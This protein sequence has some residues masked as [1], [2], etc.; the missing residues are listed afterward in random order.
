MGFVNSFPHMVVASTT[1]TTTKASASSGSYF[2]LVIIALFVLLYF[3]MI[4][5]NQRRRMQAMRQARTYDLG[6]EVVA[7]GMVGHVVKIG[8]GEVD[9][10]ISD[11]VVVQFLPQA[12]QLKSAYLAGP[13]GRGLGGGMGG[14]RPGG[15]GALGAGSSSSAQGTRPVA[16]QY[17]GG[18]ADGNGGGGGDGGQAASSSSIGS[19]ARSV[20]RRPASS[21]AWP[22]VSATGLPVGGAGTAAGGGGGGAAGNNSG[23]GADVDLTGGPGTSGGAGT[24]DGGVAPAGGET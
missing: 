8:D 24:G 3:F 15:F 13:G 23:S 5:P 9:V 2:L 12:V 4:R 7:A 10:E 1:S 20:R 22:D 16:G 11:G 19:R 17:S 18:T 21:D 6:D 14:S